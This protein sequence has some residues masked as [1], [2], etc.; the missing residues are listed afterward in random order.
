MLPGQGR[1]S[2]KI[3]NN[4]IQVKHESHRSSHGVWEF[5]FYCPSL[6][7]RRQMW[8]RLRGRRFVWILWA[9]VLHQLWIHS[10][11]DALA[12][13]PPSPSSWNPSRHGKRTCLVT[14]PL[15]I[16]WVM[17]LAR[18]IWFQNIGGLVQS[19]LRPQAFRG[20]KLMSV[21]FWQNSYQE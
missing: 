3:Q 17:H 16:L 14:L 18:L 8:F 13:V 20:C 11:S 7:S 12:V 6:C 10:P 4:K 19:A 21:S 9:S 2:N 15:C 5:P 1:Q